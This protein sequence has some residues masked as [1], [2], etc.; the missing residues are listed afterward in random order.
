MLSELDDRD[1]KI[2]TFRKY[3]QTHTQF[4]DIKHIHVR[5]P[6]DDKTN[7]PVKHQQRSKSI[8]INVVKEDSTYIIYGT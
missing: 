6:T 1:E 8:T 4:N 7:T 3:T 2:Q 5:W